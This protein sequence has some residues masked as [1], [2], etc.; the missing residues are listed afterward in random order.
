[1][2][3][4]SADLHA[5]FAALS[6]PQDRADAL[7]LTT[8]TLKD[9]A[10][11]SSFHYRG[12]SPRTA[13]AVWLLRHHAPTV[14]GRMLQR[15]NESVIVAATVRSLPPLS[16]VMRDVATRSRYKGIDRAA[17]SRLLNLEMRTLSRTVVL[18]QW[19]GLGLAVRLIRHALAHPETIYTEAFAAM[20]QVHPFL[21]KAGMTRYDR[22]PHAE[23]ARL[24][25]ALRHLDID[26]VELASSSAMQARRSVM[27]SADR[28]LFD[29]ELTRWWKDAFCQWRATPD[30]VSIDTLL[31]KARD[32]L[33]SQPVYYI[34][35]HQAR[36]GNEHDDGH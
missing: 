32:K 1:M 28:A 5:R 2:T 26:P 14:V 3:S 8:G 4:A 15:K 29:A 6:E 9:Y 27:S 25:D 30:E 13:T 22:P 31:I 10:Q 17:A 23:H 18:P 19:R 21:E 7:T 16:C 36:P 12:S 35:D 24:L 20:G 33:L 34:Y 11:L